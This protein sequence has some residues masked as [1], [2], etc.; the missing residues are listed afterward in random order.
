MG[1]VKYRRVCKAL[2]ILKKYNCITDDII[3]YARREVNRKATDP[4]NLEHEM[5]FLS[6][7]TQEDEMQVGSDLP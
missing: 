1:D 2:D 6:Y 3:T 5:R 7:L 4:Q